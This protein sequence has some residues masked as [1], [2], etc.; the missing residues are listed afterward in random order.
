MR[1]KLK[2]KLNNA[3]ITQTIDDVNLFLQRN[4]TGDKLCLAAQLVLEEVMLTYQADMNETK[5][6]EIRLKKNREVICCSFIVCGNRL[7]PELS[8]NMIIQGI[9]EKVYFPMPAWNYENGRN[10][11][12]LYIP[13]YNT[14]LKN[15]KFV[16]KYVQNCRRQFYLAVGAQ[17]TSLVLSIIIPILSAKIIVAYTNSAVEQ[18]IRM[19]IIIIA[20]DVLT[21]LAN[22]F[23]STRYNMVYNKVVSEME[24]DLAQSAL[25]ITNSCIEEKG[26]GLFIRRLT[27]DTET[28]A[29]GFNVLADL[30]FQMVR[31]IG[32]LAAMLIISPLVFV[33]VLVLLAVQ[34]YIEVLRTKRMTKDDRLFRG[35]HERFSGLVSEMIRGVA[36]IKMLNA[37][38]SFNNEVVKS[39][40]ASNN[41]QMNMLLTSWRYRLSRWGIMDISKLVVI[42]LLGVGIATGQFAPATALVLF[43]YNTIIV[44]G[45]AVL[46]I[47]QLLEFLK[48]FNLSTER[49]CEVL[50]SPEFP[51]DR[52]GKTNIDSVQG[53]FRFEHV[54]FHYDSADIRYKNRDILKDLSFEIP[55]GSTVA[56]VGRSGCG[57]TTIFRLMC[58]LNETT[59]GTVYLDGTDVKELDK[60]SLR[61]NVAV[62]SQ[63]PYIFNM[64]I[65][66]NL[67]IVKPDMTDDE[68]REVCRIACIADDIERM[69]QKYESIIGEGG[70]NFSGG[71]RQRLAI[72]RCLL[73]DPAVMLMDEATSALDNVTQAEIMNGLNKVRK[74]RTVIMI[75]HRL[76]TIV[77]SDIIMFIED[78][79][80]LDK[81]THEELLGRCS[82][83]R[84][85]YETD[86][87][88]DSGV[89][90]CC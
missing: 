26:S 44:D 89:G 46:L 8:K 61:G 9:Q 90:L 70:V 33:I 72:A 51:K 73:R 55:A 52:F 34:V 13:L 5:D 57:K 56:L 29:S 15:L 85:L 83:Y 63:N 58:K 7:D 77:T 65:R 75:A 17:L 3:D 50:N 42:I 80:V 28:L 84:E 11:V 54:S 45:N 64:S 59:A 67:Q 78:G 2:G 23:C 37:E 79:K 47:G 20:V 87:R 21:D 71:Q 14:T 16:W 60:D 31:N 40:Q 6:F 18:I 82:A 49:I 74:N 88:T 12:I 53:T 76:S 69:P 86:S 1:L 10:I 32:V 48:S 4:G 24:Y 81:G 19:G 66:K 38:E 68:M 22:Y 35:A 25:C 36:D 27:V 30:V 41:S 43:N 39:I 62:I